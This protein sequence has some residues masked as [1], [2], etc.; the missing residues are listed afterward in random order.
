MGFTA[1][2]VGYIFGVLLAPFVWAAAVALPLGFLS[3][4]VE[5]ITHSWDD[6][7]TPVTFQTRLVFRLWCIMSVFFAVLLV[8]GAIYQA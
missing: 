6:A 8:S 3:Y 2:D 1:Y 7:S 5:R 4:L